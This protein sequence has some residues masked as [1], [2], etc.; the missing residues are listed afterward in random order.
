MLGIVLSNDF[1]TGYIFQCYSLSSSFLGSLGLNPSGL[2]PVCRLDWKRGIHLCMNKLLHKTELPNFIML[3]ELQPR[4]GS[5]F[6][7]ARIYNP[8]GNDH[9]YIDM[10]LNRMFEFQNMTP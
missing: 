2:A 9:S 8:Q 4:G 1:F 10:K 5:L 7:I 3:F 6:H